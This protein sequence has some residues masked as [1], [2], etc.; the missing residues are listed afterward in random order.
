MSCIS[1]PR[2]MFDTMYSTTQRLLLDRWHGPVDF[3]QLPGHYTSLL[4]LA[5]QHQGCRFWLLDLRACAW[6]TPML[7]P[8]FSHYFA[9]HAGGVLGC[10]LF[11][12]YVLPPAPYA[13]AQASTPDH[14]LRLCAAHQV[15]PSFF[16]AKADALA[17]LH[18]QQGL[19]VTYCAQRAA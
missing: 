9:L 1:S 8:L 18:H 6:S 4:A 17:W 3:T 7:S 11:I 5:Q 12:A 10:P 2:S 15:Y 16:E 19:D 14:L 13:L